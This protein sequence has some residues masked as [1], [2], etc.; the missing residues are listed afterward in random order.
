MF[1]R[2][3]RKLFTVTLLLT[4][5]ISLAPA[6][7]SLAAGSEPEMKNLD[8]QIWSEYD[9]PRVLN[10]L[11]GSLVNTTGKE[12]SGVARFNIPKGV[13]GKMESIKVNM[14]CELVNGSEH[15]CQPYELADKGSYVELTWKMTKKLAPGEEYPFWLEYYYDPIQGKVDKTIDY[16]F[17]P[18]YKINQLNVTFKEPL[19]ATNF[20]STPQPASTGKDSENFTT[21]NYNYQQVT[22]DKPIQFKFSYTRSDTKPSKEKADNSAN[23]NTQAAN[24]PLGTS[25]WK[26]PEVLIPSILFVIVL[27]VFIFYAMNNSNKQAPAERIERIQRQTGGSKGAKPAV[28]S[29]P[30]LAKEKKK[31]RQML[32][33][34]EIS[35][36]TYR[37][38]IAEL[39]EEYA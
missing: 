10:L 19:N 32:L 4:L 17:R 37:E 6:Q 12:Y 28:S 11:T 23:Q 21:H 9:E 31:I 26:K 25:A 33:N 39:E 22:T 13:D 27:V 16:T 34:G 20:K 30:K 18:S 2:S 14:A 36:E 1:K 38:L 3:L 7:Q 8:L 24:E 35:E 29:N 5:V 15:S